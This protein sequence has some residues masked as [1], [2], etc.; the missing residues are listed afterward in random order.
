MSGPCITAWQ[1]AF[2]RKLLDVLNGYH[3]E[4][5][6][7]GCYETTVDCLPYYSD[8]HAVFQTMPEHMVSRVD[9]FLRDI[10]QTP[11]CVFEHIRWVA[12][13]GLR[14]ALE[15]RVQQ[16]KEKEQREAIDAVRQYSLGLAQ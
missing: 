6:I 5:Y 13:I 4:D 10:D 8:Y 3:Q 12:E 15:D 9:E 7:R 1:T 11:T 2:D 16:M 14:F